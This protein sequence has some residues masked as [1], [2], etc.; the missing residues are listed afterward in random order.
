MAVNPARHGIPSP[1]EPVLH[2]LMPFRYGEDV[3]AVR[4]AVRRTEDGM[5]RGRLI[6][7]AGAPDAAPATAEI[8]FAPSEADFWESVRNFREYHLR[9]I[10]RSIAE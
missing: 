2:E 7:G 1:G 8:F 9:E 6:F 5:W 3:I 10:Y 4:L